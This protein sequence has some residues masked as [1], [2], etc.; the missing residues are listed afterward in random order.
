MNS[1][2]SAFV[3]I[4]SRTRRTYTS[5][6]RG[7]TK[8]VSC[9]TASSNWSRVNTRPAWRARYSSSRN[10]VA[11]MG[12]ASSLTMTV[13]DAVLISRFRARTT[14]TESGD[15]NLRSTALT[16][17]TNSRGLNGFVT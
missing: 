3:S 1:G 7:V 10:S 16:R 2:S 9:Q 17:A 4:F 6:E 15:S 13:I 8:R 12:T 11:V 14:D 5:T